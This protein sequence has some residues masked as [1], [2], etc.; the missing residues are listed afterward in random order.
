MSARERN[1]LLLPAGHAA[2]ELLTPLGES[3]ERLVAEQ[4]VLG[5]LA[6][7]GRAEGAEQQVLLDRELREEPPAFRHERD[8]EIDDLL[9]REPR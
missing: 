1:H 4:Q 5:D 8:A 6:A 9:R 2:C 7:R 3:R